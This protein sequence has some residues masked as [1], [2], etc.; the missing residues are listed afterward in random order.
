[1][2]T[3]DVNKFRAIL[4]KSRKSKIIPLKQ[5]PVCQKPAKKNF[6]TTEKKTLKTTI[7]AL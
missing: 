5:P 6:Q 4:P 2:K 3:V 7:K 1:M